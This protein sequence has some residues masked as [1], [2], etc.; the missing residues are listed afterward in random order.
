MEKLPLLNKEIADLTSLV[1]LL[2]KIP[3]HLGERV[4]TLQRS[5]NDISPDP[6]IFKDNEVEADWGTA[7]VE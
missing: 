3:P 6:T 4:D 7:Y 2:F 1:S 5:N